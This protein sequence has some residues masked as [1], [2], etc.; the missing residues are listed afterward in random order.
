[1]TPMYKLVA[2]YKNTNLILRIIIGLI[3]GAILG[4]AARNGVENVEFGETNLGQFLTNFAEF[5]SIFGSLFVSALKAAAPIL[6]FL[7]ILS[8]ILN[9]RI[10]ATNGLKLVILLYIIGTLAAACVGVGASFLFPTTL[11]LN[12]IEAVN[13]SV[14]QN[15]WI[16]LKD[17]LFKIAD[18]PFNAIAN[19]NYVGILAWSIGLGIALKF[20]DPQTKKIFTDISEGVSKIVQFIIQLAPFGIFGLVTSAV[21][22]TGAKALL[23]Y[24]QLVV[25]LVAAMGIVALVVNPIIVLMLTRKNPYPLVFACLKDSGITAFFTRSSAANIPVN[26]SLCKKL[27]IPD[28]LSSISIPLGATINMAGAAIV[29]SILALAGAHTLGI[30]VGFGTAILLCV[31]S[32]VGACGASGVPGGSLMLIPLACSLFNIPNEVAMQIVAIGFII[33]VIQDSVETAINSS[34]DVLFTAVA[35][36]ISQKK[37]IV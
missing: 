6:V 5:A 29:I 24:G 18:N 8:S 17:L 35:A 15:V 23:G 22:E 10:G 11:T 33:G 7:L 32:A 21:F 1:M 12:D 25:V 26:L 4:F 28:E 34:T 37:Q 14:P 9:R 31:V 3:L 27:D 36:Q 30:E 19:G 13:K 20:S 16:V 2:S